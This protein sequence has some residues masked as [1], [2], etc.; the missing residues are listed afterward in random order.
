MKFSGLNLTYYS[1][2]YCWQRDAEIPEVSYD[3]ERIWFRKN[4]SGGEGGE[5]RRS[6]LFNKT[7]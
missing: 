6:G 5:G 3:L 1:S 7:D 4:I 2:N